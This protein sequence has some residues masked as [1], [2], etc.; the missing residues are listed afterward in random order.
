M[1]VGPRSG[2]YLLVSITERRWEYYLAD[3][4]KA[5]GCSIN[6]FVTDSLIKSVHFVK[7]SL[8]RRHALL[9]E[10]GAFSHKIDYIANFRRF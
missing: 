8:R 2:P 3:P 7:I 10:D 9:V 6:T 4:G 1:K 5:R